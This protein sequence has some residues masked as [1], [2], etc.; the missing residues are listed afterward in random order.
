MD[1]D[2]YRSAPIAHYHNLNA[3]TQQD[4]GEA[5]RA[6]I[7]SADCRLADKV[8]A[9]WEGYS[10][11]P[12]HNLDG[13]AKVIGV[14]S[15]FYKD[16]GARFGLGS[17]KALGGAY[18][19]LHLLAQEI[20]KRTGEDVDLSD[21][22]DGKYAEQVNTI[23]VMTATDGNHGRSVAW[24]AKY[25]GCPC[26]I[27]MH[28]G[29]SAGRAK[30]VE[31]LGAEVVW[32]NGN[33]DASVHQAAHDADKNGWFVVSDTSYKGYTEIPARVMAGYTVMAGEAITQLNMM[34]EY[35]THIFVQ[36]GVGGLA[37]AV[38]A[39]FWLDQ[40]QTRPK[41]I[42]VEPDRADCLFQSAIAGEETAVD[43]VQETIMAGLS[44][45]EVSALA[46]IVL[47]TGCDD[48]MTISDDL[49]APVMTLL[50]Q[51]EFG[52]TA[53]TAGESAVAGLAGLLAACANPALAQNL[54]IDGKSKILVF[55]SE[56]ATDPE[57]YQR[58]TGLSL[59]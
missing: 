52:D 37:A 34:D 28:A 10:P 2:I 47:E 1:L 36:G 17:F 3:T 35:P 19:V 18:A 42:I 57:I 29:V 41:F 7:N 44:C 25:C 32:V 6:V 11:S 50:G 51:A 45:G 58:L 4:Y 54:G 53:I 38:C 12:L 20:K 5:M 24:G 31:D 26:K 15:I 46:W 27:Y 39:R 14:R 13:L 33:Y 16:E 30:A 48:F 21:L 23:T 56:G 43:V 9:S 55:G 8:I 22:R 59:K 49:V 40:G